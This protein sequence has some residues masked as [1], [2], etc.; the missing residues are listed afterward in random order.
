MN[1]SSDKILYPYRLL[2]HH[3]YIYIYIHIGIGSGDTKQN[4]NFDTKL[5][6]LDLKRSNGGDL[7]WHGCHLSEW[8]GGASWHGTI[9]N[10]NKNNKKKLCLLH[11]RQNLISLTLVHIPKVYWTT[12]AD[13]DDIDG[14]TTVTT[15]TKARWR[16]RSR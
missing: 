7:C 14:W 9:K 11:K 4:T 5:K 10:K 12:R 1:F 3:N 15:M 6:S 2:F 13:N 16:Q 8:W